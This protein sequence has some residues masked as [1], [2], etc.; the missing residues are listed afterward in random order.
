MDIDKIRSDFPVL[1]KNLVYFDNA[2]T[3]LKPKSVIDAVNGYYSEYSGCAGR[4]VHKLSMK[5]EEEFEKARKNV[6]NFV[7]ASHEELVWTRNA[8]EAM[9][10]VAKS[11]DFSQKNKV[12]ISNMEHHSALLP[13]QL[14][15]SH[16]KIS[17]DFVI[18]D[19]EGNFSLEDFEKKIDRK[20]R[21][22]VLHHTSNVL[23]TSPQL[24]EITKIAHD[25]GSLILIDGAQGVPHH[26]IDFRRQ[27]FDFL[28]FSGHKMLGPTG[29]GCLVGKRHLLEELSPFLVG[30]ETIEDVQLHSCTFAKPPKKFEAGIQH[31]AGAIGLSSAVEYLKKIGMENVEKRE[32]ELSKKLLEAISGINGMKIYGPSDYK[33]RCA[34]AAFNFKSANPKEIGFMLDKTANIAVRSGLFCAQPAMEHL[35]AK[36]GAIRA[37]LYFYNTPEELEKFSVALKKISSIY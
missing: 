37:S 4:S 33:K 3:T 10:L 30:G 32:T 14:L 24:S 11:L 16:K 9:N 5:T 15:S 26:K 18:S 28:A 22:V 17:L 35:G 20:T 6:A 34:L 29:I 31:Y 36:N 13:F 23:G 19:S 2:C 1:Q 25:N 27:N 8:T 21:L 7:G 12:V